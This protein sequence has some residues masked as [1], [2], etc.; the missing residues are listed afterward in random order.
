MSSIDDHVAD[1]LY[2]R[3]RRQFTSSSCW[4]SPRNSN[5][6]QWLESHRDQFSLRNR[7]VATSMITT[8]MQIPPITCLPTRAI[9]R[10]QEERR[11]R[12]HLRPD[13]QT[14]VFLCRKTKS[15]SPRFS[16]VM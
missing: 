5:N 9:S 3:M 15:G 2:E 11:N 8:V 12:Q 16:T 7:P 13:H 10:R 1:E 6:D 4:A 14:G